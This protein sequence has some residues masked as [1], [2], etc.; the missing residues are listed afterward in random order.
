[1]VASGCISGGGGETTSETGTSKT[2]TA[3]E[4]VT[5]TW[6]STQ[7][8]PPEERAFVQQTL[9]KGFTDET[10]INVN[11]VPVSYT[12][13]VTRLDAEEKT[14]GKVT[15]D[16]VG[17]LHGGMDY[18]ASKGWLMDLSG[19]PKLE[20]RTFIGTFEK[21]SVI[22]GKKVYVPWMSATYVMVVN[23]EAFKYLPPD[24]LTEDDVM[25]G[26][27]KWTYDA[28]LAWAKK[29]K[30][31]TGQPQVGFPAG[32]RD[33]SSGSSTATSTRATRAT[34]PRSSTARTPLR[35][36]TT[37]RSSGPTSTRRAPPGTR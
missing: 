34:R 18:M 2:T 32:R 6:L 13:M 19:M 24:G 8:T 14:G 11:F 21:Y 28:F 12:D 4:K 29:L 23:K 37:S 33:S 22:N 26:T 27:D 17:D 35:C 10:G 15:I 1:M 16:V 25:K 30:D 7:L 5:L 9:L 31:S 20:G 3:T 36:G